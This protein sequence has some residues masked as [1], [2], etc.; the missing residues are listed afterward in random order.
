[1]GLEGVGMGDGFG[2]GLGAAAVALIGR[3]GNRGLSMMNTYITRNYTAKLE[4]TNSDIAYEWMLGHLAARKDFT[5]H[6]QIGTSFK[7]TQAGAIKV[8]K[9]KFYI[10][11]LKLI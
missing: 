9:H 3:L 5:A 8:L 11:F 10:N 7:K 4:I 2:L 1:M 6:Y